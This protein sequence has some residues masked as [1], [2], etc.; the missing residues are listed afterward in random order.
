MNYY[1]PWGHAFK[2][3]VNRLLLFVFLAISSSALL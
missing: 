3:F 1:D 2:L